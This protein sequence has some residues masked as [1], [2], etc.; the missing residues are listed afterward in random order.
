M[1]DGQK[2]ER[3]KKWGIK[4]IDKAQD[5]EEWVYSK[6]EIMK[7]APTN[8]LTQQSWAEEYGKTIKPNHKGTSGQTR[9]ACFKDDRGHVKTSTGH[10]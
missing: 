9:M 4:I 2:M 10:V 7:D 3:A 1:E 5:I 8:T 6:R